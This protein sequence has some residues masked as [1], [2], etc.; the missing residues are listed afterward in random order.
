VLYYDT[1]LRQL[2]R[3]A[4]AV[5]E[6]AEA[7][8]TVATEQG[9]ALVRALGPIMRGWAVVTQEQTT[10]GIVQIRQGLETYRATG[11]KFQRPH[12]LTMLVEASGILGQPEGGLA[13][14]DEALTLMEK[15]GECYYEAELHRLRGELQLMQEGTSQQA[16]GSRHKVEAETSFHKALDVARQ[17]QAKSLELRI[18]MSLS[19]LWQQQ[20]R[21]EDAHQ[22]LAGVYEWF[23][24]GFDT[25]DLQEAK[26]LLEELSQ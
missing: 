4:Q 5:R 23:T 7:A 2:S 22:L 15:T 10:E 11:A 16:P 8:I 20:G 26:T 9:F 3:D 17:Q 13:V 21:C 14:L 6:Q 1:V 25:V 24:E 18:A 12:F 19:R